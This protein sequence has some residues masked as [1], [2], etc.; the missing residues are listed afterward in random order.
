MPHENLISSFDDWRYSFDAAF[1]SSAYDQRRIRGGAGRSQISPLI[2][3]SFNTALDF[4]NG[5]VDRRQSAVNAR[6]TPYERWRRIE[7]TAD[8]ATSFTGYDHKRSTSS[9]G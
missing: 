7:R 8:D 9:V 3:N 5:V 1:T 2:T 4:P 6:W